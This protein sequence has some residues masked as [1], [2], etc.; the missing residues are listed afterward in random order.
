[1]GNITWTA[2][3]PP[4]ATSFDHLNEHWGRDRRGATLRE[5]AQQKERDAYNHRIDEARNRFEVGRAA[6]TTTRVEQRQREQGERW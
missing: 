5:E 1:M 6:Q 2:K 4:I 3:A